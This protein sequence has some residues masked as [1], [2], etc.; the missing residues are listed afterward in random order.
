M[1]EVW[2]TSRVCVSETFT[3]VPWNQDLG[4]DHYFWGVFKTAQLQGKLL[5]GTTAACADTVKAPPLL[6]KTKVVALN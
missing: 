2:P 3:R 4:T 1:A 5:A 6:A